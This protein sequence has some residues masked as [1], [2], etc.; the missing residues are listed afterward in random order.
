MSFLDIR[1]SVNREHDHCIFVSGFLRFV[2]VRKYYKID[3][4]FFVVSIIS[5]ERAIQNI[6]DYLYDLEL[7]IN[8]N[9][10]VHQNSLHN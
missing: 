2:H 10:T 7:K 3:L 6:E 1:N 5:V 9:S 8:K 4:Y